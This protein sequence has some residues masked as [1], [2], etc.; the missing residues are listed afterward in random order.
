MRLDWNVAGGDDR[1]KAQRAATVLPGGEN[2]RDAQLYCRSMGSAK[3]MTQQ[4]SNSEVARGGHG[5][6]GFARL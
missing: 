4:V 1:L 3:K 5:E 6:L 2:N